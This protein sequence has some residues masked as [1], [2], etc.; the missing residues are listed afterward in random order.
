MINFGSGVSRVLE[1]FN[2]QFSNV[3]WQ[4]GKPPLD[5]ELNYMGQVSWDNLTSHI[6]SSAPS[7]FFLDPTNTKADFTTNDHY[8]NLF[9]LGQEGSPLTANVNGWIIPVCGTATDNLLNAIKLNPPPTSDTRIDFVFLEAWQALVSPN[10]DSTNKPSQ[11]R[12]YR[13]GNV[14]Y[15][16]DNLTDDLTDPS[17][18]FET[19]K[20]VQVQYRLRVYGFGQ[21]GGTGVDLGVYVDGLDDPNI[22]AQGTASS[23]GGFTFSNMGEEL[24]DASLWRAGDGDT[25]NDLGTVDG[26]SYAIPVC[27]IFRRNSSAFVAVSTNGSPNHN[28]ATNRKPS[29]SELADPRTGAGALYA[30]QTISSLGVEDIGALQVGRVVNGVLEQS[31]EGTFLADDNFFDLSDS[32]FIKINGEIVEIDNVDTS[33][34]PPTVNVISRARAATISSF[35]D[36]ESALELYNTRPDGVYSDQ[37]T[38]RDILDLRRGVSLRGWDYTQLLTHN[39][40]RLLKNDLTTTFKTSGSGGGTEGVYTTEVSVLDNDSNINI[41]GADMLDGA[42]GIRT[43]FSDTAHFQTN[44]TLLIDNNPNLNAGAISGQY[45]TNTVWDI[46][47]DFKPDGWWN[48]I[49]QG[50]TPGFKNGTLINLYLGGE[51]GTDGARGTF[52]DGSTKEVRFIA[53]WEM[54]KEVGFSHPFKI[55]FTSVESTTVNN[56]EGSSY[57]GY[58]YP[59]AKYNFEYPFIVLGGLVHRT[60]RGNVASSSLT[61]L[62]LNPLSARFSVDLGINFDSIRDLP[63]LGGRQTLFEALTRNGE[64]LSGIGSILYLV[65]KGDDAAESN[66]GVFRIVGLS[67]FVEPHSVANTFAELIPLSTNFD[68]N[69]GF[70]PL[71][72]KTLTFEIRSQYLGFEDGEGFNSGIGSVVIGLTDI[73]DKLSRT[74]FS[75][76]KIGGGNSDP[77]ISL[78]INSKI[79]LTTTLM[80]AQARAGMARRPKD[81]FAVNIKNGGTGFIRNA[82]SDIDSSF[83]TNAPAPA[84]ERTYSAHGVQTWNALPSL[85]LETVDAP[86]LGGEVFGFTEQS[87]DSELFVDKGSKTLI[88]KPLQR[89]LM[90]LKALSYDAVLS[91]A[92]LIGDLNYPNGNPKDPKGMFTNLKTMGVDI[93]SVC[94]PKFG[95]QDIPLHQ[96]T[97][98]TDPVLG[99]LHHLF[100]DNTD[101]ANVVFNLIGGEPNVAGGG[102]LVQPIL[103]TT[104][105]DSGLSYGEA[106]TTGG[107]A[108]PCIQARSFSS[109]SVR[110]SDVG[111]GMKGIELP[112]HYGV[113]RLYGVYERSEYESKIGDNTIGAF[114]ADRITPKTNGANGVVRNLLRFDTDKQTLFIKQGGAEDYTGNADDHTYII[115][116]NVID[117]TRGVNYDSSAPNF[118][119]YE[120]IVE[121]VVFGFA[122]GFINK[123][124]LILARNVNGAGVQIVDVSQNDAVDTTLINNTLE[125]VNVPMT[126]HAP[127]PNGTQTYVGYSRLV[128]Q[129]DPYFTSGITTAQKRDF[130]IKYGRLSEENHDSLN[131]PLTQ[132][133]A[134]G[135]DK[136]DTPNLR[137]LRVLASAD[138]FTTLGTGKV[139][140]SF[141][142]GTILDCGFNEGSAYASSMTSMNVFSQTKGSA[143]DLKPAIAFSFGAFFAGLQDYLQADPLNQINLTFTLGSKTVTIRIAEDTILDG[144]LGGSALDEV[145]ACSQ[146]ALMVNVQRVFEDFPIHA[147]ALGNI[148]KVSAERRGVSVS[149]EVVRTATQDILLPLQLL[150]PYTLST[151]SS[152]RF[153]IIRGGVELLSTTTY[154]TTNYDFIEPKIALNGGNG[155]STLSLSGCIEQLP[156]GALVF[157]SDFLSEDPVQNGASSLVI[158]PSLTKSV[159]ANTPLTGTGDEYTSFLGES[160]TV[161]GMCDGAENQY[162]E[163]STVFRTHRGGSAFLLSG[164]NPGGPISWSAGNFPSSA[165]PILKGKVIAGK[166][167]LVQNYKET[168]FAS[169]HPGSERSYGG[170]LQLV[171][172]TGA[173]FG[174]AN[175]K[176]SGLNLNGVISPTGFGEGFSSAER[177][178]IQ[179]LPMLKQTDDEQKYLNTKP[180]PYLP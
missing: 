157:D 91:T 34:T 160:G 52:R 45:D 12:I 74:W 152:P 64:D 119:D 6:R 30:V 35:H 36:E 105:P 155:N 107:P 102:N 144:N 116:A 77:L 138:F 147:V 22:R 179:G 113:A 26:Y 80:Y 133:N 54:E 13:Y 46:G 112:P 73:N 41:E 37:I 96:R 156:L 16:G 154:I 79:E 32:R 172:L 81:I 143:T 21:G 33:V 128:Y 55:K 72:G 122:R 67:D 51:D 129:G 71:T 115:P 60:L 9:F 136:V 141:Y 17:V 63:I 164:D 87:R 86:S 50:A 19:T 167:L 5:S 103:F 70:S 180:A 99:G 168:A 169:D 149:F 25:S 166:A 69:T 1:N 142:E 27:A 158:E 56:V 75:D 175:V 146:I 137:A 100:S 151:L 8:S 123:N 95:R 174:G 2:R 148:V 92:S 139:G 109:S 173:V 98:D 68:L 15:G 39:L 117:H 7:G 90:S 106:G 20:R 159:F 18:A 110:S 177:Y 170:E 49:N 93:P 153:G 11:D 59:L 57:N 78:P 176:E 162:S 4:E 40:T 44:V 120:Y 114:E 126:I 28:G 165:S 24:G 163:L 23:V 76:D 84:N 178:R 150:D 66:N 3:I 127:A 82:L 135:S 124:N 10:P 145:Y 132:F 134:D 108:H 104:T 58:L 85:G 61:N 48:N 125:F 140:G 14:E 121:C 38:D 89:K 130:P 88:F 94:M 47:A 101:P 161:I 131:I 171:I 43:I 65:L 118:E 97:G 53:P 83:S 62:H 42:D 111:V 29:S 31:I